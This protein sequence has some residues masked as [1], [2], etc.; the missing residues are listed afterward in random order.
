MR[1][2]HGNN[3]MI[4]IKDMIEQIFNTTSL[5]EMQKQTQHLESVGLFGVAV[6]QNTDDTEMRVIMSG[7]LNVKSQMEVANQLMDMAESIMSSLGKHHVHFK[8]TENGKIVEN[9]EKSSENKDD[10]VFKEEE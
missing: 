1:K 3:R 6:K 4:K 10:V 7:S 5:D 8:R 9:I 2:L